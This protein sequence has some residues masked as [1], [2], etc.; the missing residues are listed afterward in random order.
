MTGVILLSGLAMVT[1]FRRPTTDQLA[2]AT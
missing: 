1:L 2:Q